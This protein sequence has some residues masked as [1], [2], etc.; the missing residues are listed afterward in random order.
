[1][2]SGD[3]PRRRSALRCRCRRRYVGYALFGEARR[4]GAMQFR[5]RGRV[6]ATFLR[7]AGQRGT[8]QILGADLG[9]AGGAG[10]VGR[11]RGASGRRGGG[12]RRSRRILRHSGAGNAKRGDYKSDRLHGDL[13]TWLVRH[14]KIR[15]NRPQF[16]VTRAAAACR[17]GSPCRPSPAGTV[18]GPST[19]RRPA[20]RGGGQNP[21]AGN[22]RE[23]LSIDPR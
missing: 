1:M 19:S 16:H 17:S 20:G 7:G 10:G 3:S 9:L 11:R 5:S 18:P 2:R 15:V 22:C 14:C 13:R 23:R 6:L 21:E 4:R 12:R 8:V